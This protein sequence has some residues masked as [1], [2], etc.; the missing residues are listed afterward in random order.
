[1]T[2]DCVIISAVQLIIKYCHEQRISVGTRGYLWNLVTMWA[3]HVYYDDA[4]KLAAAIIRDEYK[5]LSF[6]EI[7]SL[8][9][10]YFS[11]CFD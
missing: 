11:I 10:I 8:Q 4:N 9:R 3:R 5:P 1:M 7:E 2:K 6:N